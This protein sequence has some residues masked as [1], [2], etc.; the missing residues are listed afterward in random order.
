MGFPPIQL[1]FALVLFV[2]TP[3][4][5]LATIGGQELTEGQA[6]PHPVRGAGLADIVRDRMERTLPA[7][8]ITSRLRPLMPR[9]RRDGRV[10][11]PLWATGRLPDPA[12]WVATLER[13]IDRPLDALGRLAEQLGDL[14]L[15]AEAHSEFRRALAS[16]PVSHQLM[17]EGGR[18]RALAMDEL[19]A[20]ATREVGIPPVFGLLP[21]RFTI[22][23]L[24][25]A[26]TQAARLHAGDIQKS[27][28]FRRRLV[29][30][31]DFGVMERTTGESPA[32]SRGRP[33][34]F[35]RFNR[36]R[37]VEWLLARR[38]EG[39]LAARMLMMPAQRPIAQRSRAASMR[40]AGHAMMLPSSASEPEPQVG[41]GNR[42]DRLEQMMQALMSELQDLKQTRSGASERG[43]DGPGP[44]SSR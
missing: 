23:Q 18:L 43:G 7:G 31:I 24:Q 10:V 8:T 11:L 36:E 19:D 33:P 37:W 38:G 16:D 32:E 15:V 9:M 20:A 35:F 30:F 25:M 29:E 26:V 40:D 17:G 13:S 12:R 28:N 2:L 22:E 3:E 42:V 21:D 39:E 1:S 34:Q 27:S 5:R 44:G 14:S 4:G 41:E 6:I